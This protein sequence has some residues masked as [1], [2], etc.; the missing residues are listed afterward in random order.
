[1]ISWMFGKLGIMIS[2]F[3]HIVTIPVRKK[4]TIFFKKWK[5]TAVATPKDARLCAPEV[6]QKLESRQGLLKL[7]H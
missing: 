3:T 7:S 5:D 4:E 2:S 1:M 6:E